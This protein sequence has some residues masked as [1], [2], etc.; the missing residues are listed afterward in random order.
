MITYWQGK[1]R[2]VTW[3]INEASLECMPIDVAFS[4][5]G[6]RVTYGITCRHQLYG[7]KCQVPL[8]NFIKS[9]TITSIAGNKIQSPDFVTIT[10]GVTPAP[11]GWWASGFV[12][13]PTTQEIRYITSHTSVEVELLL[14]FET[15]QPGMLLI[16]RQ[17]V[18]THQKLV[19][20]NLLI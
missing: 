14:A 4:R 8:V 10:D 1:V 18:T 12:E 3:S 13:N 16:L 20:T 6:L 9:A 17:D 15:L 5:N 11:D 2:G 19:E 7:N